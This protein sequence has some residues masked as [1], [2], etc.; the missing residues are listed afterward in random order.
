MNQQGKRSFVLLG[1]TALASGL[2]CQLV[3]LYM[4][5]AGLIFGVALAVY[6]VWYEHYRSAARVVA[7]VLASAAAFPLALNAVEPLMKIFPPEQRWVDTTRLLVGAPAGAGCIGA[8]L[9]LAAG[10]LFLGPEKP[11]WNSL[12]K[13]LMWCVAGGVLVLIA[14]ALDAMTHR[15]LL[16]ADYPFLFVFW[17]P[18]M[19]LLLGAL[20]SRPSEALK[21]AEGS[22]TPA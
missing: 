9:V 21:T 13:A 3:G 1:L 16:S 4:L 15:G 20:L 19:A 22:P 8:F 14:A 6:F 2:L 5:S 17:Q 11:I 18:G 10:L 7:F 12:G